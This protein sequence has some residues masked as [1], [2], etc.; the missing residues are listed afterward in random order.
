MA[1]LKVKVGINKSEF[2]T[3][4]ASLENSV[5]KFGSKIGGILT[6]A[7]AFDSII[8]GFQKAIATGDRLQDLAN[9]FGVAAS[10]LQE[11]GNA[12]SLSGG[13]LEDVASAMNK[14][15]KNAGEALGDSGGQIAQ[16]FQKIGLSVEDLKTMNPTQLFLALSTAVSSGSLGAQAF[17]VSMELAG[18][19]AASLMETLALGPDQIIANGQ[20]MGVFSDETIAALSEAQDAITAFQNKTTIAFGTVAQAILPI[21][22]GLQAAIE[23]YTLASSA[24]ASFFSGDRKAAAEILKRASNLGTEKLAEKERERQRKQKIIATGGMGD[25]IGYGD[26]AQDGSRG[27]KYDAETAGREAAYKL[28]YELEQRG[29]REALDRF[30]RAEEEKIRLLERRGEAVKDIEQIQAERAGPGAE[31]ELAKRLAGEAG[32]RARMTEAP[33][34][35]LAAEQAAQRVQQQ[36]EAQ[37]SQA[38]YGPQ[39][40]SMAKAFADSIVGAL[41]T[42]QSLQQQL[43]DS[44]VTTKATQPQTFTLANP[45]SLG[46]IERHLETLIRKSGEFN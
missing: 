10:S 14:L 6:G 19:S 45:P 36:R 42:I 13:S 29:E 15:A 40:A 38:G 25:Q 20:A 2:S 27:K 31:L 18:R 32:A 16:A 33:E 35:V 1:E 43:A 5:Q 44:A 24:A 11:I 34:D 21:I 22:E 23:L 12:A 46:M 3:G 28:F 7:F 26:R 17:S 30:K 39:A 4:L 8:S 9:R 41:P 37:L